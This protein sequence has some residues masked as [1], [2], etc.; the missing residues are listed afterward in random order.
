LDRNIA[1]GYPYFADVHNFH[2]CSSRS[3]R[4]V[5]EVAPIFPVGE[6]LM[7]IVLLSLG[8]WSLIWVTTSSLISP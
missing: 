2:R 6:A 4:L 7:V 5:G 3:D 1:Q 8:L